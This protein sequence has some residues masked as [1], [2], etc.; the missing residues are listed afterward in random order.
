MD[1]TYR[2]IFVSDNG[3]IVTFFG[4]GQPHD[5]YYCEIGGI[6]YWAVTKGQIKD[7]ITEHLE[8]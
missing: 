3:E 6:G 1:F 7:L 5:R 8:A 2:G 4:P